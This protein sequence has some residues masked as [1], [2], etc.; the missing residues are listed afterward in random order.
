M[1]VVMR[2]S[3]K[4]LNNAELQLND[5]KLDSLHQNFLSTR[6]EE[7]ED[8]ESEDFETELNEEKEEVE[9]EIFNHD[10]LMQNVGD[11]FQ[12]SKQQFTPNPFSIGAGN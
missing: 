9:L 12:F 4:D 2:N 7:L 3:L 5:T 10:T 8:A 1:H 11:F 6:E